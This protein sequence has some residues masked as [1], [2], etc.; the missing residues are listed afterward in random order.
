[1]SYVGYLI[2]LF[3]VLMVGGIIAILR[4]QRARKKIFS[5]KILFLKDS[6]K[7]ITVDF[8]SCEIL[9][10]EYDEENENGEKIKKDIAIITFRTD[11]IN[12]QNIL[13][14]TLPIFLP[15]ETVRSLANN[16]KKSTIY[17][18]P[19]DPAQRYYFDVEFLMPHMLTS[20]TA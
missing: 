8:T 3:L 7:R 19:V 16:K 17:Y 10:R 6:G 13:F 9:H 4:Y 12:G 18:D 20:P 5:D 11:Q 14:K 1:M 2:V 15:E